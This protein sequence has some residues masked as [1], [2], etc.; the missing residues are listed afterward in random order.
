MKVHATDLPGVLL[1]E[2]DVFTDAR[3]FLAVAWQQA[4]Y[5]SHGIPECFVQDNLL[6]SQ[7]G[8]IRGLHLQHPFGQGKL[9]SVSLGEVFDVAVDV[10]LGSPHFGHA[11]GHVLSGDNHRQLYI[12]AG[13]AHGFC[14]TSEFALFHY[15]CTEAY[16]PEAELGIAWNDPDIGIGWPIPVS[17][18]SAKDRNNPLLAAVDPSRLPRFAP[19]PSAPA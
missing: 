9:V 4:E 3:G 15:K 11:T 14:V 6:R 1:I 2:P 5:A 19:A 16:H 18:M 17:V 12:P 10:R 8:T 7:R 13:F